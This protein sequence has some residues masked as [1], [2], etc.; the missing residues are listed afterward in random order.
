MEILNQWFKNIE[1][2]IVRTTNNTIT[3]TEMW[4]GEGEVTKSVADW[5]KYFIE[6]MEHKIQQDK[7]VANHFNSEINTLKEMM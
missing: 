7:D 2:E 1:V 3:V 5:C 4:E 6:I